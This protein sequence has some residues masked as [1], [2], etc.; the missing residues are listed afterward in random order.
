MCTSGTES[1]EYPLG[2][3]L[4]CSVYA[5]VS[6]CSLLGTNLLRPAR[7]DHKCFA[8]EPLSPLCFTPFLFKL[9][10]LLCVASDFPYSILL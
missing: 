7:R 6:S 9:E 3:F 2:L 1:I 8:G 10:S 4:W 5:R